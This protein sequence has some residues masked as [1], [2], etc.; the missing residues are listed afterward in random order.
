MATELSKLPSD[1]SVPAQGNGMPPQIPENIKMETS[2]YKNDLDAKPSVPAIADTKQ[3]NSMISEVQNAAKQG[4]TRLSEDIPQ[5]VSQ[6]VM[7]P[8]S[9]PNNLPQQKS[10]TPIDYIQNNATPEEIE[11]EIR[12]DNN[13]KTTVEYL[14]EEM[15]LPL[16]FSLFYYLF[17]QPVFKKFILTKLPMFFND[18]G[19]YTTNGNLFISVLFAG[20]LY[21]LLKVAKN[22][23]MY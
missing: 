9:I 14:L 13:K 23:D 5:Q 7:E 10:S 6:V 4:L 8:E 12:R 3:L 17:Q 18:S 2:A 16:L 11:N 20:I 22:F 15:K 21:S 19:N 1:P